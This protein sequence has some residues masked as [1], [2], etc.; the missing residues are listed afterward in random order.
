MQHIKKYYWESVLLFVLLCGC[1]RKE[2]LQPAKVL[3]ATLEYIHKDPEL[4]LLA[5]ALNRSGLDKV[6]ADGNVTVFAPT[7]SAFLATGWDKEK[8]NQLSPD[9]LRFVLSYHIAPGV[10]SSEN[11]A[12]FYRTF[13][14]TL[15]PDFKP[16]ISKNYLGLFFN[17]TRI[18]AG[19]LKMGD[20]VIHKMGMIS[21]PPTDSLLTTL[22]RQPDLTIFSAIVKRCATLRKG[23][24]K[25]NIT[26]M[27]P[28][29]KA[30]RDS[31]YMSVEQIGRE[32]TTKLIK[33]CWSYIGSTYLG[34]LYGSDFI[35][36]KIFRT[37]YLSLPEGYL[38]A[39]YNI[40]V[41]GTEIQPLTSDLLSGRS[42]IT[43]SPKLLR[44]NI[45]S[46]GGIIHTI[47]MAF[48]P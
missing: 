19:N 39:G 43:V 44:G 40:S 10:I 31:G 26:L 45:L 46:K 22:Y 7:D 42:H 24:V 16:N 6:L 2:S 27:A 28:N 20:G 13:P 29:D 37:D 35:G 5:Q 33:L 14:I 11:I 21:F 9:S 1:A 32:D 18:R 17:G 30:F 4:S 3:P 34:R 25:E 38:F 48:R 47:N 8:I 12:G 23:L 36:G 15:N 41:D